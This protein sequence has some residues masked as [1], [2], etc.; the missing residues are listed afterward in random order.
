MIRAVLLTSMLMGAA[1]YADEHQATLPLDGAWR[2]MLDPQDVGVKQTWFA[3]DLKTTDS[4]QL[5]GSLQAQGFGNKPSS[6][7]P[8]TSMLGWSNDPRFVPYLKS[9][10]FLMPMCGV[11]KRHYIGSAWYQRSVKIPPE[12]EGQRVVLHLERPHWQTTVWV[13][14]AE[15][16]MRDSLG[17]PHDYDLSSLLT[18]GEH[19]LTIRINNA[20]IVNVGGSAHSVSDETQTAWNGV[21]GAIRLERYS[22]AFRFEDVQ[23][24]PNLAKR[25]AKVVVSWSALK[26]QDATGELSVS[27]ESFNSAVPHRPESRTIALKLSG[28]NGRSEVEYPLGQGAQL[29]DEFSPALYRMSLHFDSKNGQPV[30]R[31]VV[32]GMREV[33]QQGTQFTINDSR[34]F[35]RGALDCCIFPKTGYPPMDVESWKKIMR[36]CREYGINHIRFH[37][38]CP[39]EAAFQAGDELGMYLQAESSTWQRLGEGKPIDGWIEP[40][41]M[42]MLKTY[43]NHPSF[44]LMTMAN[45]SG[46][47]SG[48]FLAPVVTRLAASDLRRRFSGCTWDPALPENQYHVLLQ[49]RL[50]GFAPLRLGDRPQTEADYRRIVAMYKVPVVGHE[51]GQWC[52]FPNLDEIAKYDGFLRYGAL[53]IA[54]DIMKKSGLLPL[55]KDFMMASGRFQVLLYKAEIEAALRTPGFGGFQLL[56]LQDFSGQGMAPVG[57]LDSFWESKGYATPAEFRRFCSST[58]PLARMK[59]MTFTADQPFEAAVEVAHFGPAVL[60]AKPV[61]TFRDASGKTVLSGELPPLKVPTGTLTPLG[62][63]RTALT[64]FAQAQQLQFEVRLKG[65]EFTNSWGVW[66]YP[67]K[68][69]DRA[70][71]ATVHVTRTFDEKAKASLQAGG[72]VLLV[73]EPN[74][75]KGQTYGS[76]APIFWN[77]LTFSEQAVHTSGILCDTTH[78]ALAGFPTDFYSNWQWWELLGGSSTTS[79]SK[80]REISR[81]IMLN[82]LGS[83]VQPLVRAIDEWFS[84]RNLAYVF[85]ARIG[86]G[87]LLVCSMDIVDKLDQRPVARQMRHSFLTYMASPAFA[88]KETLTT[89]AITGLFRDPNLQERYQAKVIYVSSEDKGCEGQR[90]IDGNPNTQWRSGQKGTLPHEIQVDLNTSIGMTGFTYL[91]AQS[92]FNWMY[93][94][95]EGRFAGYEFYVSD[96]SGEWGTPVAKGTFTNSGQV[97]KVLF[98][99]PVKGRYIRLVATGSL[100]AKKRVAVGEID[101]L[102]EKS[103]H[104]T[105]WQT[106]VLE[107]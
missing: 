52:A 64:P 44:V 68:T 99:A 107:K 4:V 72:S 45:E 15:A 90:A 3:A 81:P 2:L 32:F 82:H 78:P 25:S 50:S 17:T 41:A 38:W 42:R 36:T 100:D 11:P 54:R 6:K 9:D 30:T 77:R 12:W 95:A 106:G 26:A 69:D 79:S 22:P 80:E 92:D 51:V 14:G 87:K 98:P 34:I 60:D 46:K 102:T 29:W 58:V 35:L 66:V 20:L 53:E 24:Y 62:T 105:T 91:P 23:V 28:T 40:E 89:E 8:W 103:A 16:G 27:A 70:L 76:F 47:S 101:L 49:P 104:S 85:E 1:L 48:P 56:G 59:Q 31:E 61:W 21:I 55:A 37:S 33:G 10:D 65:T 19:R 86:N 93:E 57:V 74:R 84:C 75:L 63:V 7:T 67:A 13:D 97:Q 96:K 94:S 5:P 43:G 18:P 73:P 88:P 83:P 71:E 39:P